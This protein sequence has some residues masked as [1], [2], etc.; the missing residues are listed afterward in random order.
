MSCTWK[1]LLDIGLRRRQEVIIGNE[2]ISKETWPLK[3][4]AN[5]K[6]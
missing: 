1:T 6:N 2:E 3:E 4:G 5:G